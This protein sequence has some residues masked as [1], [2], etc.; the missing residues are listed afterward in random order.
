MREL[1]APSKF[2]PIVLDVWSHIEPRF[3]GVGPAAAAL[4]KAVGAHSDWCFDQVAVCDKSESERSHNIPETVRTVPASGPRPL[5]DARLTELL[6]DAVSACDVCHVHGIW[7]PHTLAVRK[8]ARK[9]SKPVVSS[10]HGM[11]EKWELANKR[12]KKRIYSRL[13]ERPSLSYS[14]CLRALSQQEA[15]DYRNFGLK[16]PIT[17]IPNGIDLLE[18]VDPAE[19]LA[20]FPEL[21]DKQVVLFLSRIHP[22]KGI[23]NLIASWPEIVRRNSAAHLLV[24]GADFA[25][26][27]GV[28]KSMVAHMG[29]ADSVT[30]CGTLNGI[31]K[32]SAL[33]CASAFCLP[34]YSEGM[35]MA[36]LEALSIG[37][38]I[39]ITKACNVDGV[40]ENGAG[41]VVSN[42]PETLTEVIRNC[43]SLSPTARSAMSASARQLART[44]YNWS[45]IGAAMRSVYEWL[46]GGPK[47][48]CV[49]S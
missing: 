4:A 13:F 44:R 47:P 37:L 1:A 2:S 35:S 41:Y 5:V 16:N 21:G 29:I 45:E 38:P 8:L 42:E 11:L 15:E 40:V 31:L 20:R 17:I 48:A 7:L 18:P 24:A 46:L 14:G 26:T 9:L 30:F 6:N 27:E 25:N 23:L 19:L 10:A 33:S 3:G 49:I 39:V 28:A 32:V 36:V 22:K 12:F 43:L 34:S